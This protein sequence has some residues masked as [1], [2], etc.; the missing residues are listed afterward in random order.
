MPDTVA[1][2][3]TENI[4]QVSVAMQVTSENVVVNAVSSGLIVQC[5]SQAQEDA[6]FL[7]GAQIV[8][9]VDLIA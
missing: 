2:N 5:N 7:A 3:V 1:V 8:I 9:R 4:E 6:A